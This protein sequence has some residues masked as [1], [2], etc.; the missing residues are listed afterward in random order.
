MSAMMVRCKLI[1]LVL[2]VI[3]IVDIEWIFSSLGYPEIGH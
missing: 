2:E 3:K 1:Y